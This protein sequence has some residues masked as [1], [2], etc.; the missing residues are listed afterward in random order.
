MIR[1]KLARL[2]TDGPD[3]LY[4]LAT[5]TSYLSTPTLASFQQKQ[6]V[7][8]RQA[9]SYVCED[10]GDCHDF[11]ELASERFKRCLNDVTSLMVMASAGELFDYHVNWHAIGHALCSAH[12]L[13]PV[14]TKTSNGLLIGHDSKVIASL[15]Y[16]ISEN[17]L[18]THLDE[19]NLSWASHSPVI[20][21]SGLF[22]LSSSLISSIKQR[23]ALLETIDNAFTLLADKAVK[24]I[25][26]RRS[27]RK[28]PKSRTSFILNVSKQTIHYKT[29]FSELTPQEFMLAQALWGANGGLVTEQQLADMNNMGKIIHYLRVKLS[30]ITNKRIDG[31]SVIMNR[32]GAGYLLNC[33]DYNFEI[34]S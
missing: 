4:D 29:R 18:L 30:E 23:K 24:P 16:A 5:L 32:R 10:C 7:I 33:N 17:E 1:G 6:W 2:L 11:I 22:P 28:Q 31:K 25:H 13:V 21:Y 27:T 3:A 14:M 26:S 12:D 15:C 20:I 9:N 8:G 19:L 34:Q